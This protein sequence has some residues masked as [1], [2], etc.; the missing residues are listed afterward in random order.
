MSVQTVL[1][2]EFCE[3]EVSLPELGWFQSAKKKKKKKVHCLKLEYLYNFLDQEGFATLRFS[4]PINFP[5]TQHVT[6]Q[7]TA[8]ATE[9]ATKHLNEEYV[10]FSF[11]SIEEGH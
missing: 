7:P 3:V 10:L 11:V 2:R 9:N 5:S 1:R 8:K 4:Q 6:L